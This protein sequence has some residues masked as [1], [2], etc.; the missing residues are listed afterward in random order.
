[1]SRLGGWCRANPAAAALLAAVLGTLV[2][3]FAIHKVFSNGALTAWRW[4]FEAWNEGNDL[5]HGRFI[6]PGAIVIA[7]LHRGDFRRAAKAPSGLGMIAV[8]AGVF[9][10][11]VAAWTLQPRI[12]LVALPLL[13]FG[14]VWFL[15]G[16]PRFCFSWC[17]SVFFSGT[18]N[19]CSVSSRA[20]SPS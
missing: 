1:M 12:A 4:A 3:F 15:W 9:A 10:F 19:R 2:Y 11:I 18:P 20:S 8:L 6:L 14:G 17:R 16:W 7:W 5:E 13:I